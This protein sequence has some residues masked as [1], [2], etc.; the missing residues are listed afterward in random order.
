MITNSTGDEIFLFECRA[1]HKWDKNIGGTG[2]I[3]YHLDVRD[4]V[5]TKWIANEINTDPSLQC[6]DLIEADGRSDIF[7]T[8]DEYAVGI[9]S[10]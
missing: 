8:T 3:A 6:A 10:F 2:M 9:P 5:K 7:A 4:E 1:F